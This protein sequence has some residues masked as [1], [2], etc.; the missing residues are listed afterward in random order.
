M[1]GPGRHIR[2]RTNG[3]VNLDAVAYGAA[4]YLVLSYETDP[5]A[6]ESDPDSGLRRQLWTSPDGETWDRIGGRKLDGCCL[7]G[8]AL[9]PSG[10]ILIGWGDGDYERGRGPYVSDDGRE[11]TLLKPTA[12]GVDS[13]YV[14]HIQ[15]TAS[16][17]ALAGWPCV[18][19]HCDAR[20]WTST[21]GVTW[22]QVAGEV[23]G[24][25]NVR[26]IATDGRRRVAAL[27][28]C[29]GYSCPTDLWVSDGDGPWTLGL[30]LPGVDNITV[31]FTGSAFVA[32]G[33]GDHGFVQMASVD[34]S[35]WTELANDG[36]PTFRDYDE[37]CVPGWVA[38]RHDTVL[39]GSADCWYW[40]GTVS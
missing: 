26:A 19:G 30:E 33:A 17:V 37:D 22:D 1:A 9:A 40:R 6:P 18:P 29:P 13:L 34:G 25:A 27:T 10:A 35:T 20:V 12:F 24:D 3:P 5:G 28:R 4:G 23:P 14:E 21:D 36:L 2:C 31:A 15:S 32:I 11:W 39:M 7:F 16:G 38:A 8:L